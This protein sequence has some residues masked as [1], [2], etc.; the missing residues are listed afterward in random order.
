VQEETAGP[1]E[2]GVRGSPAILA[3]G[4]RSRAYFA[5]AVHAVV[6]VLVAI[7]ATAWRLV[8]AAGGLCLWRLL[9]NYSILERVH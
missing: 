4:A 6:A 8:G 5:A 7:A 2:V 1:R 9:T 3:Q